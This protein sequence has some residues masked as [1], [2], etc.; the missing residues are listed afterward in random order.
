[1]PNMNP[2]QL[3][4]MLRNSG[5]PKAML[6]QM[7]QQNPTLGRALQMTQGK[8]PEDITNIARNLCQQ[9]GIDFDQSFGQFK[10]QF[11]GML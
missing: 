7:A 2:M 9:K 11:G 3:L 4:G 5:N 1:M 6:S 8:S 10:Q